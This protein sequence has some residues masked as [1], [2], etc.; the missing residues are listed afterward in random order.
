VS[1]AIVM[2]GM[3]IAFCEDDNV[4]GKGNE[5]P[6]SQDYWEYAKKNLLND[7]LVKRVKGFKLEN[8]KSIPE[9]KI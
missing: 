5:P 6:N 3:A 1:A 7:K 4:K 9:A 2:E 8:I